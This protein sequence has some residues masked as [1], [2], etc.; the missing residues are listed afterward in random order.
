MPKYVDGAGL[1][2]FWDNIQD[3]IGSVSQEQVDAW[4]DG[5]PEATTT[6][7]DG[8]ITT[9]KLADGA[10][11]DAKLTQ[12]G[13]VLEHISDL[14]DTLFETYRENLVT[15]F[16]TAYF[17]GTNG[18]PF[19]S[20]AG[21]Y[22]AVT[23]TSELVGTKI[24]VSGS[25]WYQAYPYV[26]VGESITYPDDITPTST[27]TQ[28]TDLSFTPTETGTLYINVYTPASQSLW[29]VGAA[30]VVRVVSIK[31]D[32]LPQP[33]P[34]SDTITYA[35]VEL[36]TTAGKVLYGATGVIVD[37]TNQ[38]CIV[39]DYT[40]VTPNSKVMLTTH[41]GYGQGLYAFYDADRT[42]ISGQNAG[43]GAAGSD[44]HCEIIDVPANAAFIVIGLLITSTFPACFLRQG[45]EQDALPSQM[46]SDYKWTCVGDSLTEYN[47][48][49]S[50]HYFDYVSAAT[51][52]EI[53]NMGVSGTG[54]ARGDSNN[55]M[56]RISG[57]PT[58]SDVVTIFGSGNDLGAGLPIGT[59]SDTGTTTLGGVINTTIDNLYAV[60][61]V[62]NLGIV[63]PTPW[64]NN[65]PSNNGAMEQYA[66]LLVAICN[67]R[68]IP[69]LDLY[70]CS[71]L[72]PNS[73]SVRE[74]AYSKDDGNG[75]HPDELGH[76]LIAPRFK[77]FLE[78]LLI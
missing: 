32:M 66:N 23:I 37:V 31:S 59:E 55:F 74:L 61:P 52:I 19:Y 62:V 34:V 36:T 57:V 18:T 15:T 48:R 45:I 41:Q 6:V 43:A 5:H 54:Y 20:G 46:W 1:S 30:Y 60:M 39:T 72:N 78:T 22:A 65:M 51:G 67:R 25:A 38:S 8:A 53:H 10:V 12:T 2:R 76:K 27:A 4:L 13:G 50:V 64:V 17:M 49:T 33:L 26:F 75:V 63:T 24:L 71:N 58:D 47:S 14:E 35:G 77:A 21:R 16:V 42:Y 73:A 7:Q 40:T 9:A 69:C 44:L 70:H 11:T 3:Q 56:T 28:Y 68:S 29:Q